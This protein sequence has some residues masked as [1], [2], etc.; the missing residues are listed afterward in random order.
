M[1]TTDKNKIIAEFM[2]YAIVDSAGNH[3]DKESYKYH[4]SW[5]W[6]MPV[7][8]K[9]NSLV[10]GKEKPDNFPVIGRTLSE[11]M[12][13]NNIGDAFECIFQF[14]QWYNQNK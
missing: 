9:C 5:D 10:V 3:K 6:L 7:V 8:A 14:I 12:L 13:N 4:T 2:G 11:A 1:T